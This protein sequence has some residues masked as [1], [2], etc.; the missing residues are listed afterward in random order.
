MHAGARAG[1]A[2]VPPRSARVPPHAEA[3]LTAPNASHG[4]FVDEPTVVET[5]RLSASRFGDYLVVER[6]ATGGMGAIDLA[7]HAPAEGVERPVALKRLRADHDADPA[8]EAMFIDEVRIAARISHP[9]VVPLL[10]AGV[11][12]GRWYYAMDLLFGAPLSQVAAHLRASTDE[13]LAAAWPWV[14]VRI[15]ADAC[16][17][18]HAA[19]ELRDEHGRLLDVVHRDVGPENLFVGFDGA[20][21]VI[22]FGIASARDRLQATRTGHVRGKAAFIAPER[23]TLGA[24]VDRRADVWALGVTLWESLTGR[25]LFLRDTFAETLEAIRAGHVPPLAELRPELPA[26]LDTIIA[27]ALAPRPEHRYATARAMGRDLLEVARAG[28]TLDLADVAEWMGA[29]LPDAAARQQRFAQLVTRVRRDEVDVAAPASIA[30]P[31]LAPPALDGLSDLSQELAA[32]RPS[33]GRV[34]V[35]LA[36]GALAGIVTAGLV[37]WLS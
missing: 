26:Q 4:G 35:L 15:L 34:V 19:H 14:L 36:V 20:V 10:D 18:L 9:H 31:R 29:L 16:E 12:E 5:G 22:D 3:A 32:S 37:A 33:V 27:R 21:R 1:L 25:R 2:A 24:R 28:R 6:L 11:H 30:P 13:A 8:F 23:L 17:G 7:V